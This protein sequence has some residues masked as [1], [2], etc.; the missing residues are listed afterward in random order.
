MM[1]A[2]S[3]SSVAANLR[4]DPM[5]KPSSLYWDAAGQFGTAEI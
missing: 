4:N 2:P 1:T 3:C 5:G